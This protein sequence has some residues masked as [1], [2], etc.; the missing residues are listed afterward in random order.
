MIDDIEFDETAYFRPC[1]HDPSTTTSTSTSEKL[2]V[3]LDCFHGVDYYHTT[4]ESKN[5]YKKKTKE[6][7]KRRGSSTFMKLD[8]QQSLRRSDA[9]FGR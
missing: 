5:V 8:P 6:N 1:I 2:Q 9:F 4:A 7:S 3:D